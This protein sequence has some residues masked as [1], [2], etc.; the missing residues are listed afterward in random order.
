MSFFPL[1]GH[2][3]F[4]YRPMFYDEQAEKRRERQ[5]RIDREMHIGQ[6]GQHESDAPSFIH[7]ARHERQKSNKRVFVIFL[8]L[9]AVYY[10]LQQRFLH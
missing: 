10:I 7:F 2:N 8:F 5:A 3:R 1:P 4:N 6:T 9:A